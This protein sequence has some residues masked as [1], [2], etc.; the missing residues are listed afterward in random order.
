MNNP[1]PQSRPTELCVKTPVLRAD[2]LLSSLAKHEHSTAVLTAEVPSLT[3]QY[4]KIPILPQT[5]TIG[6]QCNDS[7]F[8]AV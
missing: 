6:L 5:N 4:L 3:R 1:R 2:V 8:S 7:M